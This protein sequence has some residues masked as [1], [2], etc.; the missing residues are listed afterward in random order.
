MCILSYARSISCMGGVAAPGGPLVGVALP[1][2]LPELRLQAQL[3]AE[4]GERGAT[5]FGIFDDQKND[6]KTL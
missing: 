5:V 4:H 2:K 6:E 1:A 3:A